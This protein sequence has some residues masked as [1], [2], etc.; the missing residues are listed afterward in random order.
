MRV[1]LRGDSGMVVWWASLVECWSAFARLRREGVVD[2]AGEEAARAVLERLRRSWVEIHP[3]EEVRA[4]AGRLLRT[5]PLRAADALQ[6]SAALVWAGS[7]PSSQFVSL[8]QH[9]REAALL[10]G[11]TPLPA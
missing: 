4:R 6:L 3:G 10:E 8:D 5:H 2:L 9:L 7:P 11:L 1:L